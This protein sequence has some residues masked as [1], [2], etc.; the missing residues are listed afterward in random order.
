MSL[1][2]ACLA[3]FGIIGL[4]LSLLISRV[5]IEADYFKQIHPFNQDKCRTIDI[6]MAA[7]DLE[8]YL[9]KYLIGGQDDSITLYV[10][11]GIEAAKSGGLIAWRLNDLE[12][13][14]HSVRLENF[15]EG[16]RFQAHGLYL[17][18]ES[19]TLFVLNHAYKYGGERVEVF[20]LS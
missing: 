15:P 9:G 11:S 3:A 19:H 20:R 10:L 2:K 8:I 14:R 17:E 16:V 7:E 6:P 18:K 1:R 12:N 5:L 4:V 13:S